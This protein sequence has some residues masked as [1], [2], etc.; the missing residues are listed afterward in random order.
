[1]IQ[2]NFIG[3]TRAFAPLAIPRYLGGGG[4]WPKAKLHATSFLP[5]HIHIV[6]LYI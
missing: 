5:D 4:I 1:M 6:E 3:A 2:K